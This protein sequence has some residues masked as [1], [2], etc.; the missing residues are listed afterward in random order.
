MSALTHT[1]QEYIDVDLFQ[2]DEAE[3]SCYMVKLVKTRKSHA[4]FF[5]ING[6]GHQIAPGDHARHERALVDG[7]Y[8][9]SYYVCIP[10]LDREI[11]VLN[12]DD[13]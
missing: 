8:W 10:C 5:G 9:G 3:L 1:E 13:D 7:D 6:D 11:A 4:C 2:G 12:G